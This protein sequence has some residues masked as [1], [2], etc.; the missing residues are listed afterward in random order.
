[1]SAVFCVCCRTT[2]VCCSEGGCQRCFA[3]VAGLPQCVVL[4]VGVSGVLRVL[5]DYHSVL[6]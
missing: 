5:Q 4:R 1:M 2:T 3:C 6:F